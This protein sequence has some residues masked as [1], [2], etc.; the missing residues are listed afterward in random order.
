MKRERT[1]TCQEMCWWVIVCQIHR[2]IPQSRVASLFSKELLIKMSF[3]KPSICW[4]PE[5]LWRRMET[6]DNGF[7][8]EI[9]GVRKE[10]E[11]FSWDVWNTVALSIYLYG[12]ISSSLS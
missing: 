11:R 2:R 9:D 1:S 8:K 4:T 6:Q 3:G 10:K 7:L 5:I 12:R